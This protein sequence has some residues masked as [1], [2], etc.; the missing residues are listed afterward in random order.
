MFNIVILLDHVQDVLRNVKFLGHES[1][2]TV[3]G[4]RRTLFLFRLK[5]KTSSGDVEEK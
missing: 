2:V 5:L 4:Q 3:Q 1:Q